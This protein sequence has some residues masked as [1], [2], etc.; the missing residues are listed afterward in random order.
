MPHSISAS[1]NLW[2]FTKQELLMLANHNHSGVRRDAANK[3]STRRRLR[4]LI[5]P[6]VLIALSAVLAWAGT[7]AAAQEMVNRVLD[8]VRG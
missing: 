1:P 6:A 8:A 5:A 2:G 3:N 4:L 7:N